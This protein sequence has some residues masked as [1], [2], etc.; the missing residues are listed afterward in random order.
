M[1][2]F[3]TVID[4]NDHLETLRKEGFKIGFIPTMG[5]LH[6]GHLSL[7]NRAK[8]DNLISVC[9]IFVNPTQFNNPDDLKN[10]PRTLEADIKLLESVNCDVLF[11]PSVQEIYPHPVKTYFNFGR[12]ETVMEGAFRKGHFNGMAT[13]VNRLFEIV[14]P[15][16]AYFGEKDFQQLTIVKMLVKMQALPIKIIGC[17]TLREE[18]GLAM[19]SRNI[20]LSPQ[21]REDALIISQTLFK[22]KEL[23]KAMPIEELKDW[24]IKNLTKNPA[25]ELEYFEIADADTL[26]PLIINIRNQE[27]NIRA[28]IALKIGKTRL[29]DNMEIF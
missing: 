7:I 12:L 1:L 20:H 2:K 28:F 21:E 8:E 17:E 18:G 14:K 26:Q 22:A 19:S 24:A 25:I 4:L 16:F 11:F 23:F 15:D 10:Y 29:I 3:E 9:S 6:K 5:A 13:V 27:S